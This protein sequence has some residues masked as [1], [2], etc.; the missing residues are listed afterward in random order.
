[1]PGPQRRERLQASRSN[2][3]TVTPR[4]QTVSGV[5]TP[6]RISK[7]TSRSAASAPRHATIASHRLP[8]RRSPFLAARQI[9]GSP[10]Y[11]H[12]LTPPTIKQQ[13]FSR[14]LTSQEW[15][16]SFS[17]SQAGSDAATCP[18]SLAQGLGSPPC[19]HLLTPPT[20]PPGHVSHKP[21]K[22]FRLPAMPP[23]PHTAYLSAWPRVPQ[24][25]H[26]ARAPSPAVGVGRSRTDGSFCSR[27]LP[28]PALLRRVAPTA[29]NV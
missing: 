15:K 6:D 22:G 11:H 17:S 29:A 2:P 16:V 23:S 13:Y 25:L 1:M 12:H 24:A 9:Y 27:A 7:T 19:H 8:S 18:T 21:C 10:P 14:R 3:Q 26:R 20:Y 5:M 4:Q 28:A